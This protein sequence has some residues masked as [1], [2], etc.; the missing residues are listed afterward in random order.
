[1]K[2][3]ELPAARFSSDGRYRYFLTRVWDDTKEPVVFIGLNPSTA[4]EVKDDP[5]IRR[6]IGYAKAWGFG[7]LI[8]LNLFAYRSTDWK[9]LKKV[10]D[11]WGAMNQF[12]FDVMKQYSNTFVAAWGNHALDVDPTSGYTPDFTCYTLRNK[13]YFLQMTKKGQ[14]SHPLY[15][16]KDL[17]LRPW[18]EKEYAASTNLLQ[19]KDNG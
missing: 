1:M 17:V 9:A 14:P 15:L 13:L 7:G 18:A 8:M 3:H 2:W 5:T 12:F 11:P 16:K 10:K 6:C 19:E 4:D